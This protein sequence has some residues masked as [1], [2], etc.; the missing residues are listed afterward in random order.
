MNG[1]SSVLRRFKNSRLTSS[2]ILVGCMLMLG[3]V[4]GVADSPS[5]LNGCQNVYSGVVRMLPSSLPAPYGTTCNTMTSNPYLLEKA[6]SWNQFG[7]PGPQGPPGAQGQKGDT[8]A[9]GPAGAQG[10]AGPQG[11]Q[12][13]AGPPGAAGGT[14][15]SAIFGNGAD[16]DATLD[17][18]ANSLSRDTYYSNLTLNALATLDTNGFRLFV[19]NRLMLNSAS[20]IGRNGGQCSSPLPARTLGGSGAGGCGFQDPQG[21][22]NS[23]GGNGGSV[24]VSPCVASPGRTASPPSVSVGGPQIFDGAIA[25]LSGRTLDGALVTGGAGGAGDRGHN[26]YAG[27]GGGVVVVAARTVIVVGGYV[28]ITANGGNGGA[29]YGGAG[30]GGGGGGVVVVIS[31]AP[32][33]AGVALTAAGGTSTAGACCGGTDG[34]TAWLN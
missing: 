18:T 14:G 32:Q 16:G 24:Q 9:T 23:L 6:I 7:P 12:G 34:F 21:T 29:G 2:A 25:A 1:I 3:G 5:T 4:I 33:P 20:S 15:V 8:G 28:T 17:G 13:Q 11:P 22:T 19:S 27:T 10:P 30:G 31:S 26:C